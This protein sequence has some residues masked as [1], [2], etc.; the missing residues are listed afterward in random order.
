MWQ[1]A[2]RKIQV[3]SRED[4]ERKKATYG[5]LILA[6]FAAGMGEIGKVGNLESQNHKSFTISRYQ[7]IL[8]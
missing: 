2:R 5:S 4:S 8:H 7:I 6:K 1:L 3:S